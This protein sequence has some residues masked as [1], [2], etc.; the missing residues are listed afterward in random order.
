MKKVLSLVI[1]IF[2]ILIFY[3]KS[4]AKELYAVATEPTVVLNT[5]DFSSVFGGINGKTL[6]LDKSGLI[7]EVE[8]VALPGTIFKVEDVIKNGNKT[9]Y[10]VTT[11]D[12]PYP[13]KKGYYIDKR[14]VGSASYKP[15]GIIKRLPGKERI[16][17]NLLSARGSIYIW[18]GNWREGLPQMLEWYPPSGTLKPLTKKKWILKG[19][20]CSGLL[21]EATDG[22]T[23][24]NTSSLITYGEAL[25]I[26]GESANQIIRKVRPL[27]LI[28]WQGHVII[29]LDKERVIE[30]RL[31]YDKK[32]KGNQG[33]VRV[34]A[35]KEVLDDTLKERVP[36]DDYSDKA[37]G[38]KKFVIRRWYNT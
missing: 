38:R 3:T 2:I 5:P 11:T 29:V 10:K 9:I 30:S 12:Y 23:P 18:G 25:K 26:K 21:Y 36:V 13:T 16:V 20:D 1:L 32:R 17:Q 27:D 19:V 4:E 28:V 14:F 31:D 35:L 24:R 37:S 7:R 8:F 15:P 22:V 6:K 34:R 33:G